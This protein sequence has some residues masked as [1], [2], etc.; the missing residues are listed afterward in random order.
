MG[1]IVAKR[2]GDLAAFLSKCFITASVRLRQ[3][4][5]HGKVNTAFVK[6][7]PRCIMDEIAWNR[8]QAKGANNAWRII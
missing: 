6:I 4:R 2:Q 1:S 5:E 3:P 7:A 8:F